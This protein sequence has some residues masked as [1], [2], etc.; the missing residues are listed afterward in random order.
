MRRTCVALVCCALAAILLLPAAH[1]TTGKRATAN[2]IVVL[3]AGVDPAAVAGLHAS[4]YGVSVSVVYTHA[5]PGYAASVP[6]NRVSLL[7]SDPNVDYIEADSVMY[8]AEQVLPWGIDRVEADLSSAQAGDGEGRVDVVHAYIIDSGID[9]DHTDLRVVEHVNFVDPPNEDC[10]GH[11]THVAGTV[12]ARDDDTDVVG[13]A[14]GVALHAVKV[15][16]CSGG[17]PA[18]IITAAVD[19]VTEH[20][21]KPAV[22]NMSLGGPK[23]AALNQAVKR[24][25]DSG[26]FYSVSA[27]NSARD[28]CDVSPA[29]IGR[30]KG[31]MTVAA[32]DINNNEASFSNFGRCVDVW[33]PGV[34]ILSTGLGGGTRTL[35]GTSMSAPHVTGAGALFLWQHPNASPALVERMIKGDRVQP[36]TQSK[37]GRTIELLNVRNF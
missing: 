8:P 6:T 9:L 24:S 25:V 3:K 29:G 30:Y 32:T 17:T 26:V 23:R 27:G 35:S 31:V 10:N 15:F 1:A 2:Y 4:R 12:G 11:G 34:S 16:N 37:D 21:Q 20:A 22:A 36:G 7:A 5:L 14:P 19:W 13:M 33:A 18:S 28:A